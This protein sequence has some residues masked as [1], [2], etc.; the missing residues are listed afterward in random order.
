[1]VTPTAMPGRSRRRTVGRSAAAAP[2]GSD[3]PVGGRACRPELGGAGQCSRGGG[4]DV[5]AGATRSTSGWTASSWRMAASAAR[6]VARGER[7]DDPRGAGQRGLVG[8]L[9]AGDRAAGDLEGGGDDAGQVLQHAVAR[10]LD[11]AGRGTR[12]RRGRR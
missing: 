6:A 9:T 7:V 1:M 10:D 12:R 5:V 8:P 4:H 3:G 11:A 2:A